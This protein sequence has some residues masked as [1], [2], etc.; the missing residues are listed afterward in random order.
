MVQG[1]P[2]S[3]SFAMSGSAVRA[4]DDQGVDFL[5]TRAWCG[6]CQPG[7][8]KGTLLCDLSHAIMRFVNLSGRG[9][10]APPDATTEEAADPRAHIASL[11]GQTDLP[12]GQADGAG[13]PD[14][15]LGQPGQ[16]DT[17]SVPDALA[18]FARR[19]ALFAVAVAAAVVVRVIAMLG[20]RGP[21]PYPDSTSYV[22]NAVRLA[23]GLV[24]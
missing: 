17:G 24:R 20:F 2:S 21:L 1:H 7:I 15:P 8:I 22:A 3:R 16:P 6:T 4:Q 10:Q 19:H 12:P 5:P 11:P 9:G 23:P 18:R 14:V 13:Q